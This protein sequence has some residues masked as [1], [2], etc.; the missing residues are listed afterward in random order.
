MSNFRKLAEKFITNFLDVNL[1]KEGFEYKKGYSWLDVKVALDTPVVLLPNNTFFESA[2][3]DMEKRLKNIVKPLKVT[4]PSKINLQNL[5]GMLVSLDVST[6]DNNAGHRIFGRVAEVMLQAAGTDE[7]TILVV[8]ESRNFVQQE[9]IDLRIR[10][11]VLKTALTKLSCFGNGN[12]LGNSEG[13]VI[14]QD[15]LA[16]DLR[17]MLQEA[18]PKMV[19]TTL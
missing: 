9:L 8:E 14:A 11:E 4:R 1:N 16:A 10:H 12:R 2:I 19:S 7:N 17:L 15:A 6:D 13:N 18:C 5:T 3:I